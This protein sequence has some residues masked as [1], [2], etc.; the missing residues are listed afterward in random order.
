MLFHYL[1]LCQALNSQFSNSIP[2]LESLYLV[3]VV[4]GQDSKKLIS[5][6]YNHRTGLPIKIQVGDGLG[7]HDGLGLGRGTGLL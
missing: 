6:F 7:G 1:Q 2:R 5:S 3:D 4:L